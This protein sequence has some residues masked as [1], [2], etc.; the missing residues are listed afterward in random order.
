MDFRGDLLAKNQVARYDQALNLRSPFIKRRD[1]RVPKEALDGKFLRVAIAAKDLNRLVGYP[2]GGL[3][4]KQFG[5]G[6]LFG[7]SLSLLGLPSRAIRQESR[8]IDLRR[9]VRQ[10]PLNRFKFGY[11]AAKLAALLRVGH[12]FLHTSLRDAERLSGD[13]DAP[14]VQG[15]QRDPEAFS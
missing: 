2:V 1:P 11:G 13:A 8:R 15:R 6:G 3:G 12:R 9:H 5:H 10:H 4:R 14:A 7:E